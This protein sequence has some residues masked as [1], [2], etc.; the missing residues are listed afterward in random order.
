MFCKIRKGKWSYTIYACSRERVNG[1]VVS[2]DIKLCS[3]AWH[4]LYE[5]DEEIKKEAA[6]RGFTVTELIKVALNEYC[7]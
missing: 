6:K 3:L 5:I 1:K 2:K 7:K 4:S